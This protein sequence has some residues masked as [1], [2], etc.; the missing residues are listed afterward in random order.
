MPE[1]FNLNQTQIQ[2]RNEPSVLKVLLLSRAVP[3]ICLWT[4]ISSLTPLRRTGALSLLPP[5]SPSAPL[6]LTPPTLDMPPTLGQL[7]LYLLILPN[8]HKHTCT[9]TCA[10][11]H[12]RAYILTYVHA[13][14][15]THTSKPPSFKSQLKCQEKQESLHDI[16][17]SDLGWISLL[18]A[19]TA[20]CGF[21]C[22]TD[23]SWIKCSL[24]KFY[25]TS[26]SPTR[27]LCTKY[28]T[29]RVMVHGSHW[30]DPGREGV[31]VL[32]LKMETLR[33]PWTS[34]HQE[35]AFNS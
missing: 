18:Q 7:F 8:T 12:V 20:L 25:L 6:L 27:T 19:L 21:L 32:I 13:Q 10:H 24:G 23:H 5:V 17:C 30:T 26:V 14:T 35:S 33:P 28:I 29:H 15:C 31:T 1:T 2:F 3:N 4:P 11:T 16:L 22:I 34:N 9:H